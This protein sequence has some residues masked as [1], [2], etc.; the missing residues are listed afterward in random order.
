M[1]PGG[2]RRRSTTR[3]PRSAA[4][5]SVRRNWKNPLLPS[6]TALACAMAVPC[7]TSIGSPRRGPSAPSRT[8]SSTSRRYD[9]VA[10][11]PVQRTAPGGTSSRS[12]PTSAA[13][14][15]LPAPA[16]SASSP[17]TCSERMRAS[18]PDG[19]M[20]TVVPGASVPDQS[21]PVTTVPM[22]CKVNER[23]TGRRAR[24]PPLRDGVSAAAVR[25]AV[26]RSSR[27]APVGAETGT[28]AASGNGVAA[29]A[30]RTSSAAATRRASSTRSAFVSATTAWRTPSRARIARCSVV[31]GITPSSA[32][33]QINARSMPVAP[34]T[35]VRT[36]RSWPGTSTTLRR[37]SSLR[38]SSA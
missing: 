27:P 35:I 22:P 12:I 9:G 7:S 14:T 26:S 20:V 4:S 11:R 15:R 33:T 30:T 36:K 16:C 31:C 34:P 6:G 17:W 23:S 10:G 21:V 28:I 25:S 29:S 37:R 1:V 24:P 38:A 2:A 18:R 19:S 32:A 5:G 8:E 3:S 13:A